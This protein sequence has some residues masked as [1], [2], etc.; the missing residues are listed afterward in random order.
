MS[1][2]IVCV[3]DKYPVHDYLVRGWEALNA[4]LDRFGYELTILG[5]NRPWGGLGSKPK[6]LKR[7]IDSGEIESKCT[8]F[9]DAFDVVFTRSPSEILQSFIEDFNGLSDGAKVVWNAE[10]NCFPDASLEMYHS[11]TE[12]PY[13][14]FNSG[15]SI[16]FT[17]AYDQCLTEMDVLS[18]VDDYQ[19]PDRTW[20]HRNDQDDW[21]RRFLFGQCPGQVKME[22]D[23]ECDLFWNMVNVTPDELELIPGGVRNL[24]TGTEPMALHFAGGSKTAGLMEPILSHLK[25]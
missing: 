17:A 16:G 11:K 14:F 13:R 12:S 7:A 6:L 18:W 5:W 10:K 23:P 9:V 4:S 1:L 15:L 8:M 25:L 22:L 19:K 3:A 24:T 21:M 2:Q 20:V